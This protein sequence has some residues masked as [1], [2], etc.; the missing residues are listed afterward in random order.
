MARLDEQSKGTYDYLALFLQHRSKGQHRLDVAD[1]IGPIEISHS[2]EHGR[3][4]KTTRAVKA[5]ELLLANKAI[6]AVFP[7]DWA[8]GKTRK[9]SN[10]LRFVEDTPSA[11]RLPTELTYKWI[12]QPQLRTTLERL[13]RGSDVKQ[14]KTFPIADMYKSKPKE[15]GEKPL[16]PNMIDRIATFAGITYDSLNYQ[17]TGVNLINPLEIGDP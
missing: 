5:G 11:S 8:G 4:L 12:H 15:E 7:S 2:T 13:P 9:N 3:I 14:P 1:Y 17:G 16:D 6:A 10:L